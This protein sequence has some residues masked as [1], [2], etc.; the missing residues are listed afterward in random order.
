MSNAALHARVSSVRQKEADTIAS[1]TAALRSHAA[2]LG[3]EVPE[4]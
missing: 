3:L 2:Q 4:R 1:Q